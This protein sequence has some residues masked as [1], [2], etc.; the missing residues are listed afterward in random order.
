M[1][2]SMAISLYSSRVVL[3]S[4][5]ILD[6]G[7]FSLIAGV[8][9]LLSFLNAAMTVST[10]RYLSYYLGVNVDLK[11]QKIFNS[12]VVL[13]L[14]MAFFICAILV[15]S[16]FFLFEYVLQIPEKNV[17]SAKIVFNWMIVS[18]FFTI[19]SVPF[20]AILNS[21]ENMIIIAMIE[22]FHSIIR[23]IIALSLTLFSNDRLIVYGALIASLSILLVIIKQLY[24]YFRYKET[25]INL[26][27]YFQIKLLKELFSF[28]SWNFL[29]SFSMLAKNQGIAVILNLYFGARINASYAI[30]NQVDSQL[31]MFSMY[32]LKSIN[33]QIAISEGRGDRQRMLM[34]SMIASKFAFILMLIFAI[35]LLIE[36]Q[37]VLKIWLKIVP[38]FTINFCRLILIIT[39]IN[40]LSVG[41]QTAVQS[42]GNIKFYQLGISALLIFNLPLAY[43]MLKI[44]SNPEV[45]LICVISIEVIAFF[46]RLITCKILANLSIINYV[47]YVCIKPIFILVITFL[48]SSFTLLIFEE[49]F[50]RL[51][52]TIGVSSF[53]LITL[54]V[55]IGLTDY[56]KDK[57][58]QIINDVLIVRF[59]RIKK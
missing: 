28:S 46:Y 47:K 52:I 5:G 12:S 36:M 37:Y 27:R 26:K 16:G 21:H 58:L 9:A 30:A 19:I 4:L 56:E 17:N 59:S 34:L 49:S 23:L 24:C 22:I 43:I 35:P 1:L 3:N 6:Y 32:M 2:F 42:V 39:M 41:I 18:T 40:L 51:L 7:I 53:T 10:Q 44:Y 55:T 11:I 57:I 45:V 8:I 25:R 15:I 33:P 14:I 48:L 20:D 54:I 38:E 50:I 29:G 13:H 31:K